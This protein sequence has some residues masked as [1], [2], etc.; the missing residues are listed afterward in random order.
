MTHPISWPLYGIFGLENILTIIDLHKSWPSKI[1]PKYDF[2]F[3]GY[4]LNVKTHVNTEV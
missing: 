3:Q 1:L 2:W 4:G